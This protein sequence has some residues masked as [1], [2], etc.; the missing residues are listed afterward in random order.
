MHPKDLLKLY[1]YR[2]RSS[3]RLEAETH[4]NIEV[5]WLAA[6]PEAPTSK[7][8]RLRLDGPRTVVTTV[9]LALNPLNSSR[10]GPLFSLTDDQLTIRTAAKPS[11]AVLRDTSG[12]DIGGSSATHPDS[13]PVGLTGPTEV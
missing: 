2:V 8:G 13:P 3:R 11:L 7:P 12:V 5:I 10:A 1:I 9:D 4:R 6:A